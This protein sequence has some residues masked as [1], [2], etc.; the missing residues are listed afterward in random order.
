M[1]NL[2]KVVLPANNLAIDKI[3]T[4]NSLMNNINK[5]FYRNNIPQVCIDSKKISSL[6]KNNLESL[7]KI[8][9][10]Y[11]WNEIKDLMEFIPEQLCR[12]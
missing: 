7:N 1:F 11:H 2:T 5:E 6:I 10:H 8:E 12:E 4:F 3:N 9:P